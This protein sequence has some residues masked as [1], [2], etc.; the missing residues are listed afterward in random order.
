MI[1]MVP[2]KLGNAKQ[3]NKPDWVSAET[4]WDT[5]CL[6][7]T[8][9]F[10]L[11]SLSPLNIWA[12][13]WGKQRLTRGNALV[14][15]WCINH[16]GVCTFDNL[17]KWIM[18]KAGNWSRRILSCSVYSAQTIS[19]YQIKSFMGGSCVIEERLNWRPLCAEL[20]PPFSHS[21]AMSHERH[22]V[23]SKVSSRLNS[24]SS[25][26]NV[27]HYIIK[28]TD[29]RTCEKIKWKEC[30]KLHKESLGLTAKT[31]VKIKQTGMWLSGLLGVFIG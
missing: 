8:N 28:K 17:K 15:C 20:H 11:P 10:I 23:S 25:N 2:G 6:K 4:C 31:T 26:S 3:C 13:P 9:N 21:F 5:I 22:S 16:K 19:R 24:S 27:C 30:K 18:G 7:Y 29:L 14:L 12:L 1:Q